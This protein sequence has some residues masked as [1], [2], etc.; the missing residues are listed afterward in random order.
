MAPLVDEQNPLYCP[1]IT[2]DAYLQSLRTRIAFQSVRS[3]VTRNQDLSQSFAHV[4]GRLSHGEDSS[5]D[6]RETTF[7]VNWD[8]QSQGC[9]ASRCSS[10]D[11]PPYSPISS[12][13][14]KRMSRVH[15]QM[16]DGTRTEA[17]DDIILKR[18]SSFSDFD[19]P[20]KY[21]RSLES[22]HDSS[23]DVDDFHETLR[24]DV[25]GSTPESKEAPLV[26]VIQ[27]D[28]DIS[29]LLI[30]FDTAFPSLRLKEKLLD[31]NAATAQ[32]IADV[33][34]EHGTHCHHFPPV[35]AN[36]CAVTGYINDQALKILRYTSIERIVLAPSMF[37]ENGLNLVGDDIYS[38]KIC[39]TL[40]P[41][42]Y[43]SM[44]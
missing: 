15:A 42:L 31:A 40:L 22:P 9:L 20:P 14:Q 19:A 10:E 5:S 39:S 3:L 27:K 37:D 24:Y 8:I 44:L 30:K 28:T 12:A 21:A 7:R 17:P 11:L 23:F 38:S 32:D 43:S 36:I 18:K 16:A 33:L 25:S 26:N 41:T 4:F 35:L 29:T 1:G 2:A 13:R 6:A 34:S